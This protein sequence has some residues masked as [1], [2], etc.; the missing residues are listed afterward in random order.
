MKRNG[1]Q[2]NKNTTTNTTVIKVNNN[3]YNNRNFEKMK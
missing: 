2:V 3:V 1:Q